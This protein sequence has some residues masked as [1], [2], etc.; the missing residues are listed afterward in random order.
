LHANTLNCTIPGAFATISAATHGEFHQSSGQSASH[1]FLCLKS[2]YLSFVNNPKSRSTWST[3]YSPH[4]GN[5]WYHKKRESC[6][7]LLHQHI[8]LT[9]FL[10]PTT[11]TPQVQKTWKEILH[12]LDQGRITTTNR[13][14]KDWDQQEVWLHWHVNSDRFDVPLPS[15]IYDPNIAKDP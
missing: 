8:A 10:Q 14:R 13:E 9:Y 7:D 12:S 4:P 1:V 11:T 5:K 2:G 6:T 3:M 15:L